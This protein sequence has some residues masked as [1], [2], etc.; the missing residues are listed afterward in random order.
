MLVNDRGVRFMLEE[1]QA[2]RARAARRRGAR[3]LPRAEAAVAGL[4]RRAQARTT[5]R[6][7]LS[8]DLRAL[9]G[10]RHRSAKRSHPGH[11]GRALH[12][13]RRSSP[14]SRAGRACRGSTRAAR[15]RA[16]GVH[17][18]NRLASNSLLEGLVFA[19]RV[20][21]DLVRRASRSR[22]C[23]RSSEVDGAAARRSRR[24][25]GCGRRDPASDVGP[26]RDRPHG[27]RL[28][29]RRSSCSARS[30]TRLPAGATE[31]A[32]MVQTAQ[33][34]AEAALMRKESRGGHYRSD[35]PR[36]KSKWTRHGTSNW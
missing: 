5:V 31:E 34:I 23:R 9:Q 13:G 17:G 11:A 19:E 28:A 12:D 35:F 1:A 15:W 36:A 27:R 20:A 22:R 10:A 30:P 26:R 8:R 18:A 32:N 16:P 29:R 4:P 2:R 25:A 24:R 3:D 21:R 7:A 14:I 6:R 33:L